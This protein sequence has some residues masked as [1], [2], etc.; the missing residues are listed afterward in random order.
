MSLDHLE[1]SVQRFVKSFDLTTSRDD[2][3]GKLKELCWDSLT[4]RRTKKSLTLV[5]KL[6]LEEVPYGSEMFQPY[7][8]EIPASVVAGNTRS[9]GKMMSYACPIQPTGSLLSG[10]MVP[11]EQESFAFKFAQLWNEL[12]FPAT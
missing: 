3:R 8:A 5:Y 11:P 7:V 4:I 10:I 1:R 12:I 9:A 6:V 2:Y